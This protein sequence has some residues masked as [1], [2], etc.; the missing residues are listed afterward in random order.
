MSAGLDKNSIAHSQVPVA[1]KLVQD[2]GIL[3]VVAAV[4]FANVPAVMRQWRT[5]RAGSIKLC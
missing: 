5:D 1:G 4:L 2:W 3:I